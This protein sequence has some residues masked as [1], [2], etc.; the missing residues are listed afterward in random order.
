MVT[1]SEEDDKGGQSRG[2]ERRETE[3][4]QLTR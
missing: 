1:L 2:P 4:G 3:E